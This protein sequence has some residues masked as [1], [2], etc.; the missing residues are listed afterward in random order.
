MVSPAGAII[1]LWQLSFSCVM[2]FALNNVLTLVYV[3]YCL[4]SAISVSCL[5]GKAVYHSQ[6]QQSFDVIPAAVLIHLTHG[7]I[8]LRFRCQK[9]ILEM[10]P[11]MF[12]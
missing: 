8:V 1:T 12:R 3:T 6:Q 4:A 11:L 10:P 5:S 2:H 7:D 9:I